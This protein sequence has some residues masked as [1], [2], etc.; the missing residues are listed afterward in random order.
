MI[1]KIKILLEALPEKDTFKIESIDGYKDYFIVV[2]SHGN[3]CFF[4]NPEKPLKSKVPAISSDGININIR[5]NINCDI[6]ID[7]KIVSEKLTVLILKN[8]DEQYINQF[9]ENCIKLCEKLGDNPNF[10]ELV[11][12]INVLRELFSKPRKKKDITELGLWGELLLIY[13]SNK[14]SQVIDSWHLSAGEIYDFNNGNNIIEVKTTL[15][16]L[17]VHKI[18]HK[19]ITSIKRNNGSLCSIMTSNI[20]EGL[21]VMDLVEKI[22]SEVESSVQ[23]KF[24]EKLIELAG[25]GYVNFSKKY[26]LNQG[27]KNLEFYNY[28]IIP[29]INSREIQNEIF[30]LKF[31]LNIEEIEN[32]KPEDFNELESIIF[33]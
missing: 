31:S 8:N 13:N 28:D 19:Q 21:S 18:S 6:L 3:I 11:I 25:E 27:L 15:Q 30:D 22:K 2:D 4:I 26:D 5:Y 14:K 7:N 20:T 12:Y 10:E 16:P 24:E 33:N 23:F 9:S 32:K 17:R 1:E 29:S